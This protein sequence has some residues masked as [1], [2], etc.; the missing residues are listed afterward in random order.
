MPA[1]TANVAAAPH[2]A[3]EADHPGRVNDGDRS[4]KV[5]D[6]V[7]HAIL[8]QLAGGTDG[9]AVTGNKR[10]A[11]TD[12]PSAAAFEAASQLVA[13]DMVDARAT[14]TGAAAGVDRSQD[15]T[16]SQE[17]NAHMLNRLLVNRLVVPLTDLRSKSYALLRSDP[18]RKAITMSRVLETLEAT[19][20]ASPKFLEHLFV[21]QQPHAAAGA[22]PAR[23]HNTTF[24]VWLAPRLLAASAAAATLLVSRSSSATDA[25]AP[26][27]DSM[28]R[29]T[30]RVLAS[31]LEISLDSLNQVDNVRLVLI[32]SLRAAVQALSKVGSP[33]FMPEVVLPPAILVGLD[34]RGSGVDRSDVD[35]DNLEVRFFSSDRHPRGFR[36]SSRQDRPK[37]SDQLVAGM[38]ADPSASSS[39]S[40]RLMDDPECNLRR[41]ITAHALLLAAI[42]LCLCVSSHFPSETRDLGDLAVQLL[43]SSWQFDSLATRAGARQHPQ[44]LPWQL[45][46]WRLDVVVTHIDAIHRQSPIAA[47]RLMALLAMTLAHAVEGGLADDSS[48]E[49]AANDVHQEAALLQALKRAVDAMRTSDGPARDGF[50]AQLHPHCASLV[51]EVVHSLSQEELDRLIGEHDD[52]GKSA[53]HT[54]AAKKSCV[55]A[56]VL[57]ILE[58]GSRVAAKQETELRRFGDERLSWDQE[59]TEEPSSD[60]LPQRYMFAGI[61]RSDAERLL[62]VLAG[63]RH[64][65]IAT[66]SR[67]RKRESSSHTAGP[68]GRTG[69]NSTASSDGNAVSIQDVLAHFEAYGPDL[70]SLQAGLS[71]TALKE[72]GHLLPRCRLEAA[73][74]CATAGTLRRLEASSRA[75]GL[76]EES[77][78]WRCISCDEG[79]ELGE[80][81]AAG[82]PPQ[83]LAPSVVAAWVSFTGRMLSGQL[84]FAAP[85]LDA[86]R[87][88]ILHASDEAVWAIVDERIAAIV[89]MGLE[90][91]MRSARLATGDMATAFLSRIVAVATRLNVEAEVRRQRIWN[92]AGKPF[93]LLDS[94]R[95]KLQEAAIFAVASLVS[96]PDDHLQGSCLLSLTL[97]LSCPNP[98][99]RALAHT[100]I[101]QLAA[102]RRCTTFQLLRPHLGLIS[103]RIVD[104][105]SSMP[106]LWTGV[107]N[108]L[109]MTQQGFFNA[110]IEYT[111]PHLI[112][113]ICSGAGTGDEGRRMVELIAR[114][115][116]T[117]VAKMCLNHITAIFKY[118]FLRMSA[119][120]TEAFAVLLDLIAID[121]A[122]MKS[123]LRSR[124]HDVVGY[125]VV[126]LGDVATRTSAYEGL[127]YI[128]E[129]IN[130]SAAAHRQRGQQQQANNKQRVARFLR[131]EILAVLAWVNQELMGEHGKRSV[132]E[133]AQAARS[134]G[135]LVEIIGPPIS[136]V[137]PQIMATLNSTLQAPGL[138]QSTLESWRVFIT[139]MKFDDIGPFV[140][141]TA[142]ALLSAWPHLDPASR[143]LATA[144]LRYLVVDNAEHLTSFIKDIPSLD[145]LDAEIPTIARKLRGLRDGWNPDSRLKNILDR[146]AHENSAICLQS[147]HEL[148]TFL[149]EEK[150]YVQNLTSGDAFGPLVGDCV[151][152]LFAAAAKSDSLQD[153]IRSLCF[154]CLGAIGAVDPD[155]FDSSF[156][157]PI[158]TMLHNLEDPDE[159]IDFAIHLI[160]DL[161]VPAFRATD[162]TGHQSALAYAIQELL[163]VCGFTPAVLA[164][165]SSA[166]PVSVKT[167]QRWSDLPQATLDT[168]IPL[169]DSKYMVQV[170]RLTIRETP[171]YL[172]TRSYREWLQGWANQLISG[173]TDE[174][175]ISVFGIFRIAIRDQDITIARQILPHVLLH[176]LISGSDQAKGDIQL[177]FNAVLTD[178]V[179][180]K[181]GYDAE[182]RLLSAQTI[183]GLMDHLGV[184]MRLKRQSI[185]KL[186]RRGRLPKAE[187]ALSSVES[188]TASISQELTAQASLQC[189]AYARSLLNF[190]QRIRSL[191]TDS[192]RQ[193]G[194]LQTYYEHLHQIY[195]SL[196][197]PDG[198]EGISTRVVSPSLEHQIREH[199][200]TGR[201]TSAQSCWE[202]ELQ[203]RPDDASL[204]VGLLRCLR[205]LGHYDTM[206]T[207]IRGALSVHPEW[208][209]LLASFQVE[210]A[211]ILG[212]WEQLESSL[213]REPTADSP[214]HAIGRAILAMRSKDSGSFDA[215][216]TDARRQL[217]KPIVAAGKGSYSSMYDVVLQLHMLHELQLIRGAHEGIMLPS[218]SANALNRSLTSR[219][220]ATLPSFRTREPILSLRRTAFSAIELNPALRTEVGNAWIATAKIARRAGHRQT[221]YSAMLQATQCQAPFAFIQRVKLLALDEQTHKAIQDLNNSIQS[222]A[223]AVAPNTNATATAGAGA[224][225]DST[226]GARAVQIDRTAYAKACLLRARLL[227]A[228]F[229]YGPTE[230]YERYKEAVTEHPSSEKMLYYFGHYQDTHER[231]LPNPLMQ[232]FNVCKALLRS[233]QVGTKYFYRTLPRVLTIWME[234]AGDP[235]IIKATSSRSASSSA[236]AS[237]QEN[238][239]TFRKLNQLMA[240]YSRKL[241][242]FQWLAVF[243]QLVARIVQKNDEAWR[244]LLDIIVQVVLAYP[245]QAMWSMVA[246][247]NSKDGER[248]KR[249]GQIVATVGSKAPA[250]HPNLKEVMRIVTGSQSLAK[251]LLRLCDYDVPRQTTVLSTDEQFPGLQ[252]AAASCELLLPLQSSMTISLPSNNVVTAEHRPFAPN[253]PMIA[254]F[255]D[256]IEVM[257]SLQKPR[258]MIILGSDGRQYPFLCKPKDD[259]R[260]DARLMEFDGMINKL[261]QSNAESRKRKLYVR[262]YAVLILNEEHGLIEWVAHTVGLRHVLTRLYNARG[263]AIYNHDIR[264]NMDEARLA[265]DSKTTEVIFETKVLANFPPVFHEWF[266]ATFPEPSAWLSARSSYARTAAV[267]SMVGFVLGLG[268]RHGENI[269]FDASSGDTVHVDL[270]CLFDKGQKFEIPERVPFRLT[271]NMV[272]AFGVTGCEG[273]FRKSAE[274]TMTILRENRDSLMSVL[275][276]M[277]H[278]P[279]G[280]WGAPEERAR[281]KNSAR[282]DPRVAEARR[283]LDPVA[284]KLDG[285]IYRLG[286]R[287]PTPPY[288]TNNLVDSLI[289]EATSSNNLAKMYVGWSSWL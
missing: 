17:A 248:R 60:T 236:S 106:D 80:G 140:G 260:K 75:D 76:S 180:P 265:H 132:S 5:L 44:G 201:W 177:E 254:G 272:D 127:E 144:I 77:S 252:N 152:T 186:S 264:K 8:G 66:S 225:T 14:D 179:D 192:G 209:P 31:V 125:L 173:I 54:V 95:P 184:W 134:I 211:C 133:R 166:R 21:C 51:R 4:A 286:E 62:A 24:D 246:G 103:T 200:S 121:A 266:L 40:F 97:K 275:E 22:G 235:A 16:A 10:H 99:L 146:A 143:E 114:A 70:A 176:T 219:L 213:S 81:D 26:L 88:L 38:A 284:N 84:P 220:N 165:G 12:A 259:L 25:S 3:S 98:L 47:S 1:A 34:H 159:S 273:V 204:H 27:L 148:R 190:E 237:V 137:T 42:E 280:E 232:R 269:L 281:S 122:N 156:D 231:V 253:L 93:G 198:M 205:S 36:L 136:A 145:S 276:A 41:Q 277:V 30:V 116:G 208:E 267:M 191:K 109:K 56:A 288:S 194:E 181:T 64:A 210:G 138:A 71:T 268:D 168:V 183:F 124:Q 171:I 206:R 68:D 167:R 289:K 224:P 240:K 104:L 278:D 18:D 193:D 83:A 46:A 126:K 20:R 13:R 78:L 19:M 32:E 226:A 257:N 234:V 118:V 73:L 65:P 111:L 35:A 160:R 57:L 69:K 197:E 270:N 164:S 92:V 196:D 37:P 212:D 43:L 188:L 102:R 214:E 158:R 15:D 230:V 112:D 135:A 61:S 91:R 142:A 113:M 243:P 119:K 279:L 207:H 130:D 203:Q 218:A 123:L 115:L 28:H 233:A 172:H 29:T 241:L 187:E 107:L 285:R 139:T 101:V 129:T 216:I 128:E 162:D 82:R 23:F 274:V 86:L 247:S 2:S 244:V 178:Q 255:E 258:K 227:D 100:Q 169:L 161:L 90:H 174:K 11:V 263:L 55:M 79:Q 195:A 239:D 199:E 261:L 49:S 131:D 153:D 45:H 282:P 170:G 6:N 72:A 202:V 89:A 87:R 251:E 85:C 221:A 229:R 283:A 271:H 238:V 223:A 94:L 155:R 256:R 175:A 250:T 249:F 228:T 9:S 222:V 108:L 50:L 117:S 149:S 215:V 74:A 7:L 154:D 185:S 96:V 58:G 67:K 151:R 33:S 110:T 242:P 245:Q 147:L 189:K 52:A 39:F 182:R 163:K 48:P 141:Q 150:E 53:L 287:E 120:R 262:T 157:E 105:F 59:G 63:Q 217:G